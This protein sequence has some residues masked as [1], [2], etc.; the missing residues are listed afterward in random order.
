MKP[1]ETPIGFIPKYEDL[2]S[3]FQELIHK[4]YSRDLYNQQFGLYI[5]NI[6]A[7]ID[8]QAEAF[9]KDNV[10]GRLFEVYDEQR[11][12]LLALKEKIRQRGH[13]GPALTDRGGWLGHTGGIIAARAICG[14]LYS[15]VPF[16]DSVNSILKG[17]FRKR[18]LIRSRLNSHLAPASFIY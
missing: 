15:M 1:F 14:K 10:P 11:N 17:S 3:L 4:E 7:R 6:I 12:G 8:M 5:D 13:P 2:K 16:S 9:A 18:P